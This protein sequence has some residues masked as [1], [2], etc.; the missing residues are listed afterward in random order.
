MTVGEALEAVRIKQKW[1]KATMARSLGMAPEN[2]S[3][4]INNNRPVGIKV[5]RRAYA[6]G[7]PADVLLAPKE[8]L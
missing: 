1:S 3:S 7:V 8:D 4:I 2:Y 6:L 5:A